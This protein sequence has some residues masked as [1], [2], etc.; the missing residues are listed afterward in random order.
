MFY[1]GSKLTFL[2]SKQSVP[3]NYLSL[4]KPVRIKALFILITRYNT[5]CQVISFSILVFVHFI[6]TQPKEVL[7]NSLKWPF[8]SDMAC[9][10][11]FNAKCLQCNFA[12][13][14]TL[15][16][17]VSKSLWCAGIIDKLPTRI[18]MENVSERT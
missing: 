10:K 15:F 18:Q 8:W 1:S 12:L 2:T 7:Q 3:E 9:F 6:R 17:K 11:K 16:L 14:Q 4:S 13:R 5:R